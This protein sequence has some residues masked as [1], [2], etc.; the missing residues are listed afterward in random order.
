VL[1]EILLKISFVIGILAILFF[2]ID[3][4]IWERY[5][6]KITKGMNELNGISNQIKK[7]NFNKALLNIFFIILKAIYFIIQLTIAI[8]AIY[9]FVNLF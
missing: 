7:K 9:Y 4:I 1:F 5:L 3:R 2:A 6:Y 8:I